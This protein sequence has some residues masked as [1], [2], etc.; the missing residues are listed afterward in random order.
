MLTDTIEC[1]KMSFND[2][3]LI[4]AMMRH[5]CSYMKPVYGFL[6]RSSCIVISQVFLFIIGRRLIANFRSKF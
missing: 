5:V 4:F 3:K 2:D 1:D 6:M